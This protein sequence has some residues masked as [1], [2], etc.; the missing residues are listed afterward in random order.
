MVTNVTVYHRLVIKC[1]DLNTK[2]R[3]KKFVAEI[4]A[5]SYEEALSILLKLVEKYRTLID[6][7]K[8]EKIIYR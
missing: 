8:A 3:F 7:I 2:R 4:D 5:S 1:K 6:E